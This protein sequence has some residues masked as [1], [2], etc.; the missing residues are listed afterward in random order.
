MA[1]DVGSDRCS[2]WAG[3]IYTEDGVRKEY[4]DLS[5]ERQQAVKEVKK[6]V[7]RDMKANLLGKHVMLDADGEQ[8]KVEFISDGIKHVANDAMLTLSGKYFSRDSMVHMDRILA[9]STYVPTSHELYKTRTDGKDKF[10]KYVDSQ[11]R[12]V[13]FGVAHDKRGPGH[14][15]RYYLYTVTDR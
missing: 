3:D 14:S 4:G 7:V 8:I 6:E 10:F 2:S 12:G 1:K 5:P 15:S 13:Y 9:Q 11:G